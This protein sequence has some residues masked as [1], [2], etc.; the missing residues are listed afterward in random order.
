MPIVGKSL[1]SEFYVRIESVYHRSVQCYFP[2]CHKSGVAAES[3]GLPCVVSGI[4]L[5]VYN[6][7]RERLSVAFV[8]VSVPP[9]KIYTVLAVDIYFCL[10][11]APVPAT[12]QIDV[13]GACISRE[14][15]VRDVAVGQIVNDFCS[16]A[17]H[18]NGSEVFMVFI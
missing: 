8:Y 13:R 4:G 5:Y 14:P 11:H 2:V 17:I 6:P 18:H 12:A 7:F 3:Y 9:V 10:Y 1:R 15:G 16:Y